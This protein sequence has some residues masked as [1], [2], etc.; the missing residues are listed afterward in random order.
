MNKKGNLV[1]IGILLVIILLFAGFFQLGY[2]STSSTLYGQL[3]DRA[4]SLT[5]NQY[6][7][8]I[9]NVQYAGSGHFSS[10]NT[11]DFAR[12]GR[13]DEAN[14]NIDNYIYSAP[15]NGCKAQWV[16]AVEQVR[17]AMNSYYCPDYIAI[18]TIENVND[19]DN[20]FS[21]PL[22]DNVLVESVSVWDKIVNWWQELMARLF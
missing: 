6:V 4:D 21:S 10:K 1:G 18:T 13:C 19:V 17:R 15:D 8:V 7:C 9:N 5:Y 14:D 2:L 3:R 12:E 20:S 11:V 16:S 22:L